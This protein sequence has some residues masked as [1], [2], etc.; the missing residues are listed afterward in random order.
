MNLKHLILGW[1]LRDFVGSVDLGK[2]VSCDDR[3][4]VVKLGG[5]QISKEELRRLK[6]E[7]AAMREFA[8]WKVMTET[9]KQKAIEK[10]VVNSTDF[11]QV[12]AGKLMLHAVG[13]F[14]SV[15]KAV[16]RAKLT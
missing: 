5:E 3:T 14:E 6:A 8:L 16:E 2:V 7:A 9:L 10:A 15:I 11:E 13:I 4:G 12:L 1:A